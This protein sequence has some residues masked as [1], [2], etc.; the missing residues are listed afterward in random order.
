MMATIRDLENDMPEN[1]H[2]LPTPDTPH[3][4][5]RGNGGPTRSAVVINVV[6]TELGWYRHS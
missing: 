6:D 1:T 5:P 3:V 2:L 4:S